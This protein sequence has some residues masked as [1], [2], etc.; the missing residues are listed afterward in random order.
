LSTNWVVRIR[1][2]MKDCPSPEEIAREIEGS[3][4]TPVELWLRKQQEELANKDG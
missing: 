3:G 2:A 4:L 1:T